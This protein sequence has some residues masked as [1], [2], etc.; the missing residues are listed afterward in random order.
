MDRYTS[1]YEREEL[2][3]IFSHDLKFKPGDIVLVNDTIEKKTIRGRIIK[4]IKQIH[5]WGR[6]FY[7]VEIK[8]ERKPRMVDETLLHAIGV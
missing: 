2:T 5:V 1:L 4:L 7:L 6:E 8:G 3:E